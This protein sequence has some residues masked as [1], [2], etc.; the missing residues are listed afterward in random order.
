MGLHVEA[1]LDPGQPGPLGQDVEHVFR[2]VHRCDPPLPRGQPQ[3]VPAASPREFESPGRSSELSRYERQFSRAS[4][5]ASAT[6]A[7]LGWGGGVEGLSSL[8]CWSQ[9][10]REGEEPPVSDRMTPMLGGG[11]GSVRIC[12]GVPIRGAVERPRFSV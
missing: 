6:K 3:G 11:G 8:Y 2:D 9:N 5:P 1:F 7:A 10:S 4:S 12:N